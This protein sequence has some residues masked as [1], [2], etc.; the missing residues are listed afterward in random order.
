MC[1]RLPKF[2]LCELRFNFVTVLLPSYLL[3]FSPCLFVSPFI[4]ICGLDTW[5]LKENNIISKTFHRNWLHIAYTTY[6]TPTSDAETVGWTE[7][8]SLS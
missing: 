7:G 5:T 3:K 4:F 6:K 2:K 8:S 1:T